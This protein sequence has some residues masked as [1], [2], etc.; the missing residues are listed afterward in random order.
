MKDR[1]DVSGVAIKPGVSRNKIHYTKEE[2]RKFAPTLKNLS[3]QKDHNDS[4]DA[5]I[6]L[7]T[8]SIYNTKTDTVDYE[9]WIKDDGHQIMEKVADGRVSKVSIGAVC[10]QLMKE[11]GSDELFAE[12]IEGAELSVVTVPGVVGT[13]I[14]QALESIQKNKEDGKTKILPVAEN[15]SFEA[16]NAEVI[17]E[18]I[19]L[20]QEEIDLIKKEIEKTQ[21]AEENVKMEKQEEAKKVE[22]KES[23]I[24]THVPDGQDKCMMM[25]MKMMGGEEP[26]MM[27]EEKAKTSVEEKK[28]DMKIT[29]IDNSNSLGLANLNKDELKK[30]VLELFEELKNTVKTSVEKSIVENKELPKEEVKEEKVEEKMEEKKVE[31]KAAPTVPEFKSVDAVNTKCEEKYDYC[32]EKMSGGKFAMFVM[33]DRKTGEYRRK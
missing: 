31:E 30:Q 16:T 23:T 7:V 14:S 27:P 13:S 29:V 4:V 22:I 17:E 19:E 10:G 33:P 3:I 11:E 12:N 20:T 15:F 9:G 25:E 18:E 28:E 32:V 1:M 8:N 5:S 6:G 21:M 2:L 24:V 26:E